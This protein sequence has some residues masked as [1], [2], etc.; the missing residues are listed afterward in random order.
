MTTGYERFLGSRSVEVLPY[1]GGSFVD[2]PDRRLRLDGDAEPG[3]WR[4]EIRG[5]T[6]APLERA[7]APDLSWLPLVRAHSARGYLFRPGGAGER[8]ELVPEEELALFCPVRARRGPA[9]SRSS[10][11]STSS[12]VPRRPR[13]WRSRSVHHS[14]R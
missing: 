3:F 6:A 1:F 9:G 8:L 12:R 5:R 4:F 13:A 10:R 7:E 11:R 14:R 2:A